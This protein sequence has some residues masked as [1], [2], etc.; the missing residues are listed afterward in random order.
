MVW[1]VSAIALIAVCGLIAIIILQQ[2]MIMKSQAFFMIADDPRAGLEVMK[3]IAEKKYE[4]AERKKDA[5]IAKKH[6][7]F[8][9][10]IQS[11]VASDDEL[12]EFGMTGS[13]V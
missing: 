2:R 6:I 1:A 11:G 12:K 8:K 13:N 10:I 4:K 9:D 5:E 3:T 7:R